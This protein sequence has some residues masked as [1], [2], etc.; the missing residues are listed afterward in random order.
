MLQKLGGKRYRVLLFPMFDGLDDAFF[1][2]AIDDLRGIDGSVC[3]QDGVHEACDP[4][5]RNSSRLWLLF[6]RIR[7]G[8]PP[9]CNH[10][11]REACGN[12]GDSE[13]VHGDSFEDELEAM[14]GSVTRQDVPAPSTLSKRISPP[15]FLMMRRATV[16]PRPEPSP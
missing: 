8:N 2:E 14:R 12:M 10:Y 3:L 15:N 16:N 9:Q 13:A 6:C 4:F 7:R 5:R 1:L 11:E